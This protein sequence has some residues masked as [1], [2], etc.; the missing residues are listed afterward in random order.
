MERFCTRKQWNAPV[1][2]PVVHPPVTTGHYRAQHALAS[3]YGAIMHLIDRG[4]LPHLVLLFLRSR[5]RI[6]CG[7][8]ENTSLLHNGVKQLHYLILNRSDRNALDEISKKP[9][10]AETTSLLFGNAT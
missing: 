4:A 5:K 1:V 10:D 7:A 6:R 3:A 8:R 9:F 2:A